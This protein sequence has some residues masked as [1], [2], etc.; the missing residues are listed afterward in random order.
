MGRPL[1]VA[2]C[3]T[4]DVRV[5]AN[6]EI[7]IEGRLL[8]EVRELEG[9]FGE[10]PQYYGPA[11][12]RQVIAVDAITHRKESVVP[13]HRARGH[14]T[15]AAGC[16]PPGSLAHRLVATQLSQRAR[17]APLTGRC[18]P[19]SPVRE[20]R[21]ALGGRAQEHHHGR[22]CRPRRHQAGHRRR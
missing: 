15:P 10:F 4:N 5:P 7:V 2:R 16:H 3:V 13:H 1:E 8:P 22:V 20:D 19:L 18:M 17:C 9:P 11:G 12:K 21:Q 14:G 6:A